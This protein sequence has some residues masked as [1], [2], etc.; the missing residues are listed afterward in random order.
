MLNRDRTWVV[1]LLSWVLLPLAGTVQGKAGSW[2]FAVFGDCLMLDGSEVNTNIVSEVAGA[3]TNEN[4]AFLLFNGDCSLSGSA[5]G[6]QLWTNAMS[7]LYAA[8]IP[9]YPAVGN[10]DFADPNAFSNIVAAAAPENGPPGEERTTYALSYSNALVVVLNEFV[11]TN[12]YRVNQTWLDS[13]LS[14]NTLPHVFVMGHTPAFQGWHPDYL[15]FYATNRDILWNSLS[16]A[17]VRIYFCGHD[18]LYD[19]SQIDD[20]DG[21]PQN[22]LHQFVVGTGGAPLYPDAGYPGLNS[23][24]TPKRYWHEAQYGFVTVEVAGETVTTTWK[25]R[26]GTN[27]Y[28]AAEAFSYSIKRLPFLRHS[29][30]DGKLTLTWL[31]SA[32]LQAAGTPDGPFEDVPN[33]TSPYVPP[34]LDGS[35]TFYRLREPVPQT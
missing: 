35:R 24:W 10:H 6:L 26:T 5:T 4:P 28:V 8:G 15:G 16:N 2:K 22:D 12:F 3:I 27:S 32:V 13:I 33:A 25:H 34:D 14:S 21:D 11:A 9:I 30:I 19:H 1:L 29:L 23:L 7:P 17:H 31:G 18:H 20:G